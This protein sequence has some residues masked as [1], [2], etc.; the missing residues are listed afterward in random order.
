[1]QF[2][3]IID[4]LEILLYFVHMKITNT[5]IKWRLA[6]LVAI[7]AILFHCHDFSPRSL[8]TYLYFT[9]AVKCKLAMLF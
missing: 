5:R 8:L 6:T 1:M 9:F 3:Q 7:L 4:A 2:T